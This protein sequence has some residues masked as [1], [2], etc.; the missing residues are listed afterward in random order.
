MVKLFLNSKIFLIKT[1]IKIISYKQIGILLST[2][3]NW[4]KKF[5]K[6]SYENIQDNTKNIIKYLNQKQTMH[7]YYAFAYSY[8]LSIINTHLKK[9]CSIVLTEKSIFEKISGK[10]TMGI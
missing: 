4:F 5:V 7:Y 2:S 6:L 3:I 1:I 10:N 8:G 9:N